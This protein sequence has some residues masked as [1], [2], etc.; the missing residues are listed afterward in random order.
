MGHARTFWIAAERAREAGGQLVL[1]MEDLDRARCRP[2]FEQAVFDD[3]HWLGLQ[4]Q[5]GPDVGGPFAPYTQS[6]RLESYR[7]LWRRLR[8]EGFIY[9]C[10]CSRADVQRA[11][12]APHE[13]DEEPIYPGACRDRPWD[14]AREAAGVHWRFRVPPG[15][16]I[17]FHDGGFG[18]QEAVAGRDFGDFVVWRKDDFP[19]YQLAVV[20]DDHAMEITEVVRGS[21]L[22]LSTARQLL[23]Y[24]ALGWSP[25]QFHHC[26][27]VTDAAGVRLAKRNAALSLKSLRERGA[28]P[29]ETVRSFSEES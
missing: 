27:L 23:L 28:D 9:P 10:S 13:G 2:E 7:S 11:L 26:R 6:E 18:H 20:A 1:R 25:P 12:G 21:D 19:S 24:R 16:V 17:R 8:D 22:L 29:A 14:R 15:E 3:L 5:E 4:W